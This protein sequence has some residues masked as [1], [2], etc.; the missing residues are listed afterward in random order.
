MNSP[1]ASSLSRR[2]LLLGSSALVLGTASACSDPVEAAT[3]ATGASGDKI[4][5]DNSPEQAGRVK[6]TFNETIAATLPK[7]I[8]DRG[9]LRVGS[10]AV[11]GAPPINFLATDN[12]TAVGS[13]VDISHLV[14]DILGLKVETHVSSWENLFVGLD[15]GTVDIAASN[16]GVSEARK[17]KYDF[18]TYRL[19]L[20]AF[21][22][23]PDSTLKVKQP[24]DIAGKKV[25][26]AS[27]TLQEAV[28]L[29][30]N[31]II[32]AKGGKPASLVYYSSAQD[33]YLAI[34]SGRIDLHLGPDPSALYHVATGGGTKIVGHVS[35]SYPV[36]GKVGVITRKGNGL[37]Q[38]IAAALN[39][40]IADGSYARVLQRWGLKVE[41]VTQSE[42]NPAG[43]P[44]EKTK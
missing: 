26:V 7:A 3:T 37:V 30:W 24:Q 1:F 16:V 12:K 22:A 41:A 10:S 33:A 4:T 11:T 32:Q 20:H 44:K 38:P 17:E 40:A 28:L 19:G 6:G 5:Y 18:A 14:A 35:S 25:G 43:L 31:E 36:Q 23:A 39:A 8:R 42:V 29:R 21:E 13:D 9:V 2:S 15:A 27:G 34:K